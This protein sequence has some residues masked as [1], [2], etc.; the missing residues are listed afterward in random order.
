MS[1]STILT[2]EEWVRTYRPVRAGRDGDF[3]AMYETYG[4]DWDVVAARPAE[5][6]WT[7]LDCDSD[8]GDLLVAG[9]SFVNRLGYFIC[10]VPWT[11]EEAFV[12][13]EPCVED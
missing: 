12:R 4:D 11:D 13:L 6:V 3:S 10:E 2:Y 1:E 9:R 8:E 5:H 7:W